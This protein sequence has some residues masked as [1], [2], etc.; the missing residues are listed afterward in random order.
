MISIFFGNHFNNKLMKRNDFYFLFIMFAKK[1]FSFT[2]LHKVITALYNHTLVA[3]KSF[4]EEKLLIMQSYYVV[5]KGENK[6]KAS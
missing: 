5:I 1:F 6:I 3:S 2:S 4:P